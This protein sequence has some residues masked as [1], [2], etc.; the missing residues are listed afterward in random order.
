MMLIFMLTIRQ[1]TT[2]RWIFF[3]NLPTGGIAAL[4]LLLCLRV[5]RNKKKS[6]SQH[7]KEF[8]Y[9]GLTL[10]TGG[11]ASLLVGLNNGERD[12]S[13]VGAI[14]PLAIGAAAILAGA[15]NEIFTKQ[16]P[17][18]PPRLFKTRTTAGVLGIVFAQ[19]IVFFAGAFFLP[20]YFQV[21]GSSALMAGVRN[22]P[23]ALGSSLT[24]MFG[25]IVVAKVYRNYKVV[26]MISLALMTVSTH[27]K[28]RF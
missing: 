8:D 9:L 21:L 7:A 18:I 25:G 6:F 2:W 22:L 13:Q 1:N 4:I 5:P 23:F 3:I 16:S 27:F 20:T 19:G 15:V 24:S 11:V 10:L 14:V 17:V 28:M 12:W 26:M